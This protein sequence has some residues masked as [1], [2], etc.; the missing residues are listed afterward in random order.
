MKKR[1]AISDIHGCAKTFDALLSRIG[2]K[3]GDELYLLGDYIDR[4]PDSKGVIDRIMQLDEEGYKVICLK[5]N[6]EEM[7]LNE[8]VEN[9]WPPG[10]KETL[11]SF[12]IQHNN[13]LPYVYLRWLKSLISFIE[14]DN[15]ILVHA[16]LNFKAENPLEDEAYL[17]WIRAWYRHIDMD[18]LGDRI[19]V[20]GHTPIGVKTIETMRDEI[21]EKRVLN[22]DAGCAYTSEDL[23]HLCC[24]DLDT[25]EL[26][27]EP[28]R[29]GFHR[30]EQ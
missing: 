22:I 24:F 29:D 9:V 1:Y 15:Y 3:K 11:K 13:E 28:N 5:G 18:W 27:F 19:I 21:D 16:G 20:H 10:I 7:L 23:K 14:V 17:L 26:F 4:G 30:T 25:R 6:H 2:F 8:L 12:G